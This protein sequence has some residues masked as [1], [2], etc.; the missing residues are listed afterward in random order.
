MTNEIEIKK[1]FW[2]SCEKL[3][4]SYDELIEKYNNLENKYFE[5]DMKYRKEILNIKNNEKTS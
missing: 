3:I 1:S 2:D 5:L 4:N